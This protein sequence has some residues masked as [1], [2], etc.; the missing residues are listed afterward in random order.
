MLHTCSSRTLLRYFY[1]ARLTALRS[2]I[3]FAFIWRSFIYLYISP[4]LYSSYIYFPS[5]FSSIPAIVYEAV[6][7]LEYLCFPAWSVV[8][9]SRLLVSVVTARATLPQ[10]PARPPSQT[11]LGNSGII[12]TYFSF[13]SWTDKHQVPTAGRPPHASPLRL[14]TELKVRLSLSPGTSSPFASH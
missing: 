11:L 5:C 1:Y 4:F 12:F 13:K 14:R 9:C 8:S 7:S 10:P 3:L 6:D 2:C